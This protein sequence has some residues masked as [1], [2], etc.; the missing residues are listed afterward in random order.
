M[1]LFL[2]SVINDLAALPAGRL[3]NKA[4]VAEFFEVSVPTV[5]AWLR[6][7][8]PV[9]E[10]GGRG[11][12]WRIDLLEVARWRFG[13]DAPED[14]DDPEKMA[15]KDRLDWY[16]GA[17]ERTKHLQECGELLPAAEFER[18]LSAVLQ[19]VAMGLESLP[20]ILERD[21]G[22]D[23]AAIERAQGVVDRLREDLYRRI[24]PDAS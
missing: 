2:V 21:A 9:V 12:Q 17:R 10:R 5:D 23:G 19:G 14:G 1:G 13:G 7:G 16:K 22:I 15:P 6:R 8:C 3:A 11:R 24:V 4:Q 20:D 18:T